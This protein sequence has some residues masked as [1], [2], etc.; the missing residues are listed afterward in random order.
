MFNIQCVWQ[1]SFSMFR[2]HTPYSISYNI[3]PYDLYWCHFIVRN[4]IRCNTVYNMLCTLYIV[5]IFS[6]FPFLGQLWLWLWAANDANTLKIFDTL[7][8]PWILTILCFFINFILSTTLYIF[9]MAVLC[10]MCHVCIFDVTEN[11]WCMSIQ[12]GI[13]VRRIGKYFDR[14]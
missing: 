2:L 8:K 4:H 10:T 9:Y 6:N 3:R 5:G 11:L 1:K 13:I 14:W 12:M 7:D